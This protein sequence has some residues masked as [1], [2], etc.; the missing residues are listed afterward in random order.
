MSVSRATPEIQRKLHMVAQLPAEGS[1]ADFRGEFRQHGR[2]WVSTGLLGPAGLNSG[3]GSVGRVGRA[4]GALEVL[5][6]Q[7]YVKPGEDGSRLPVH[8]VVWHNAAWE[9][10]RLV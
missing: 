4:A 6:S 2:D 8:T 7:E 1:G 3:Q 9:S 5:C 10:G